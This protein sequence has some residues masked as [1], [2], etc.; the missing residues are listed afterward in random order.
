MSSSVPGRVLAML[1]RAS[2]LGRPGLAALEGTQGRGRVSKPRCTEGCLPL[3]LLSS[4]EAARLHPLDRLRPS[5]G[6]VHAAWWGLPGALPAAAWLGSPVRLWG[7][8]GE[9]V[10]P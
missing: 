5:L 4:G 7:G 2:A 6:G 8:W 10:R 3:T 9:G 1:T